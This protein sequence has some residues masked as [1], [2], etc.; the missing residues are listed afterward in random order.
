MGKSETLRLGQWNRA[1]LMHCLNVS[2]A[3]PLFENPL[4]E[5]NESDSTEA[6]HQED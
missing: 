2:Q 5:K 6:K 4:E 3:G 1:D